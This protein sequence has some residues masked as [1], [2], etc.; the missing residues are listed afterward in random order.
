MADMEITEL[1]KA[2]A[3]GDGSADQRLHR[4]LYPQLRD[5]A[6]GHRLGWHGDD[7]LNTT[8]LINE[9]RLKLAKG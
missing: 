5:I 6:L 8:A 7:T 1:L 4:M 9:A 3:A 2:A